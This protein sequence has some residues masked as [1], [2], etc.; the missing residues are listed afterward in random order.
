MLE[1][2][3]KEAFIQKFKEHGFTQDD[4]ERA[5]SAVEAHFRRCL[6]SGDTIYMRG[7]LKIEARK[8]A[9]R[10]FKDNLNGKEVIFGE[11][12]EHVFRNLTS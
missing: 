10:V 6:E 3:G 11:R 2:V 9:P 1:T 5:Y 7:V 4:A 12:V 8:R